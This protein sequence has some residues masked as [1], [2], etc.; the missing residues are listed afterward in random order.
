MKAAPDIEKIID[1][2]AHL[3][4]GSGYAAT[5]S[6]DH[7][8]YVDK[9]KFDGFQPVWVGSGA[10]DSGLAAQDAA[11]CPIWPMDVKVAVPL[12]AED[13]SAHEVRPSWQFFRIVTLN[14]KEMRGRLS[15]VTP[16]MYKMEYMRVDSTGRMFS[17][18]NAFAVVNGKTVNA[19]MGRYTE[20]RRDDVWYV[21]DPSLGRPCEHGV[22]VHSHC[23]A[24]RQYY[25]WS[26]LLSEGDGPRARFLTDPLGVREA[27]RL[28]DIPPGKRRRAA[29]RHWVREHWRKRRDAGANDRAWI[30]A[31]LRG[32]TEFVWNG[33]RCRIEPSVPDQKKARLTA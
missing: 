3:I 20:G 11:D 1:A 6:H 12:D 15:I 13:A 9:M 16:K 7:I 4:G 8:Q 33:L 18:T 5:R 26:V 17:A 32:A 10:F 28:R 21:S 30:E 22:I 23:L 29:L 14:P 19:L 27:F 24:L 31:Y 25:N 2:L